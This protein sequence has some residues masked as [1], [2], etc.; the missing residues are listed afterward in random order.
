MTPLP[1]AFLCAT[2]SLA[3][4]ALLAAAG[5]FTADSREIFVNET[6]D[7]TTLKIITVATKATRLLDLTPLVGPKTFLNGLARAR[8]GQLLV[9]TPAAL[10]ACGPDG[11]GQKIA[12]FPPRFVSSDV[13]CHETSGDIVVSGAFTRADD[14]ARVE[15][16]A[17]I[18][19]RRDAP[20]PLEVVTEGLQR[21]GGVT[22]DHEGNLWF[23]G[24]GDLWV[25][26]LVRGD[27]NGKPGASLE[28][29]RYAPLGVPETREA[30]EPKSVRAIA[31]AGDR[32]WV[33][34]ASRSSILLVRTPRFKPTS[35]RDGFNL[36]P[37]PAARWALHGR[38][39]AGTASLGDVSRTPCL[40]VSADESLVL[41]QGVMSVLLQAGKAEAKFGDADEDFDPRLPLPALPRGEPAKERAHLR[42][43]PARVLPGLQADLRAGAQG[44]ALQ[45]SGAREDPGGGHPG[46]PEFARH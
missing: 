23:A 41:W 4:V 21:I 36:V 42:G 10:F 19:L 17:L 20:A 29:Y 46:A 7:P 39:F 40:C 14:P 30:L 3:P 34:V 27:V 2:L 35:D 37:V 45:R 5:V 38:V 43:G 6:H 25:G 24:D 44:A 18:L 8:N 12:S 28:S 13:A 11:R 31:V 15:R 33:E 1:L 32:V 26:R 16:D 9:A 22:F